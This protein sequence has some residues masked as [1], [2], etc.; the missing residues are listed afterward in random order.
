M[1]LLDILNKFFYFNA[2]HMRFS[3]TPPFYPYTTSKGEGGK[4]PKQV[5]K[6]DFLVVVWISL[7]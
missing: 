2:S 7:L 1:D 6:G 4:Y 5:S 3:L